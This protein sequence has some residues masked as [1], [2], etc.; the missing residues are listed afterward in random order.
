M[1]SGFERTSLLT[2]GLQ[3]SPDSPPVKSETDYVVL[4]EINW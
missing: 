4:V 1:I 3:A 2:Q